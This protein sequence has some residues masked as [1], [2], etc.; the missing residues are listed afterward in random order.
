MRKTL[1]KIILLCTAISLLT[2]CGSTSS[3][4]DL[5]TGYDKFINGDIDKM[6]DSEKRMVEGFLEWSNDN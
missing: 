4:E 5:Y 1:I 2:G 6:T 3:E